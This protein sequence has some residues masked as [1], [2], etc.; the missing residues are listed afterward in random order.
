MLSD[1]LCSLLPTPSRAKDVTMPAKLPVN[2]F[3]LTSPVHDLFLGQL[4]RA[5]DIRRESEVTLFFFYA[6]WCGQSVVVR[7]EL[8]KV[9][10]TLADQ[11][12]WGVNFLK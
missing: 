5:E 9:A 3:S 12:M 11:V 6:P 1:K 2:F 10:R 7:E 4:D 8:E